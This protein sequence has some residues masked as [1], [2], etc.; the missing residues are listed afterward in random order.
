M[1]KICIVV[2]VPNWAIGHLANAV[3]TRIGRKYDIDVIAIHPKAIERGE[4]DIESIKRELMRFDIIDFH[5]WRTGS[6]L[7]ER[8]PELKQKILMVT[9]QNDKDLFA[10]DWS[11]FHTIVARTQYAYNKL[12]EKYGDKVT[13]I[14]IGI[15]ID[16]FQYHGKDPSIPVIGYVGALS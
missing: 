7:V 2:D 6:Q 12:K 10:A 9:H 11:A 13:M 3:A 15:D 5:Y 8:I 1:K 14:H 4:V 16:Q